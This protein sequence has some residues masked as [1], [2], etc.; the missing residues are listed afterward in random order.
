MK[1]VMPGVSNPEH[2]P[3]VFNCA[4]DRIREVLSHH[5]SSP[6]VAVV[7]DID[8]HVS[9]F[10]SEPARDR[11]VCRLDAN[12]NSRAYRPDLHQAVVRPRC[13]LTDYSS[14]QTRSRQPL[15]QRNIFAKRQQANLIILSDE[16]TLFIYED[17]RVVNAAA[18]RDFLGI[19]QQR[20]V[21]CLSE[22]GEPRA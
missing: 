22:R 6:K 9:A 12:E 7:R 15:R 8:Q 18:R 20:S 3:T 5:R 14:Y 21:V 13:K 2:R 16:P 4:K 17:R 1:A 19:E 10:A 11:R